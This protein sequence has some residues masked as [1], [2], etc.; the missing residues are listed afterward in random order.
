MERRAVDR[1]PRW[2]TRSSGWEEIAGGGLTARAPERVREKGD[3]MK[4]DASG[5]HRPRSAG[6]HPTGPAMAGPDVPTAVVPLLRCAR[7]R[8]AVT[9]GDGGAECAN[10]HRMAFTDGYLDGSLEPRDTHQARTL[11]RFGY[12]WTAFDVIQPEDEEFWRRYFADVDLTEL[13]DRVAIDVGCGK[14]RYTKFTAEYVRAMVA[15]DGS[16]AVRAAVGNLREVPNTLVVKAAIESMPVAPASFGFVSC[17]GVL[18]HLVDPRAGFERVAGLVEPG[19]VLLVY[20]Y[21]RPSRPGLRAGALAAA[22]LFRRC[23]VRMPHR[24]LRAVSAPVALLLYLG[25]VVPG[26]HG[27]RRLRALASLPLAFYR[28]KP[29]RSLWLD[30]FDRLGAPIEHRYLWRD[31]EPWFT[32]AGLT[33]QSVRE[34]SG[35]FIV[36][37]RPV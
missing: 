17:L 10:G 12:E 15:L 33:V 21:S 4:A 23:T 13:R 3:A 36:A 8:R 24:L 18:H 25:F 2:P 16:D 37:R 20:L 32:A 34:E 35:L 26:Q 29:L 22:A 19:G 5:A 7:C 14:G 31:V 6:R 27:R 9:V 30:T 28:G 11:N 1:P